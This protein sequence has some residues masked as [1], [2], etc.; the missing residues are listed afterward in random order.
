[1]TSLHRSLLVA[2]I[3]LSSDYLV[4]SAYVSWLGTAPFCNANKQERRCR[5]NNGWVAMNDKYGGA[6]KCVTGLK[7]CC[8]YGYGS[9]PERSEENDCSAK[10]NA[11]L[12]DAFFGPDDEEWMV[13]EEL[14]EGYA[15]GVISTLVIL[16]IGMIVFCVCHRYKQA[17]RKRAG[18]VKYAKVI[19]CD[20]TDD[21]QIMIKS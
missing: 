9:D 18:K 21:E 17:E 20:T 10:C 7:V 12:D 4:N 5:D 3:V 14:V 2:L 8:C 1:M 15:W 16:A 6:K 13:S 11:K 19:N